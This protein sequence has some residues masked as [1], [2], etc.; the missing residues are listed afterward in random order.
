[1]DWADGTEERRDYKPVTQRLQGRRVVPGEQ[2]AHPHGGDGQGCPAK[3]TSWRL[4]MGGALE[5]DPNREP[6]NASDLLRR[7][8]GH[9]LLGFRH[10]LPRRLR[11]A[12]VLEQSGAQHQRSVVLHVRRAPSTIRPRSD[13]AT[14][15]VWMD[16]NSVKSNPG[17]VAVVESYVAQSV[18]GGTCAS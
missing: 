6:G 3:T 1:M 13:R 11:Q 16:G 7:T 17:H 15:L 18:E 9:R 5:E 10:Q 2:G 14:L 4:R 8:P 12:D